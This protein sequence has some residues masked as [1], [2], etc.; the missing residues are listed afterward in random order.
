MKS[1]YAKM[2]KG[3]T[4]RPAKF[5][6]PGEL[7][8]EFGHGQKGSKTIRET[9]ENVGASKNI[10][11]TKRL[12]AEEHRPHYVSS[13]RIVGGVSSHTLTLHFGDDKCKEYDF[14]ED[15]SF[16][17]IMNMCRKFID[18]YTDRFIVTDGDGRRLKNDKDLLYMLEEHHGVENIDIYLELDENGQPLLFKMPQ[19][20]SSIA[21]I[22]N[23]PQCG[24]VLNGNSGE[25]RYHETNKSI[26]GELAPQKPRNTRG[27]N[28]NRKIVRLK[29]TEKLEI[30]F[31]NNR[32]VGEN[33]SN[34]SRHLGIIV[35][36]TNICP[37][38]VKTW[39]D[40]TES[41]RQHMWDCVKECFSNPNIELYRE[42]TLDHMGALWTTWRSSLN[43]MYVI[44]AKLKRRF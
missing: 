38:R 9:S 1:M 12:Q 28:K 3:G 33:H 26:E 24:D 16:L 20:I 5:I 43:A 22:P 41:S 23:V 31:Y 15:S 17:D 27:K 39:K 8:K 6:A 18:I 2:N 37:V 19:D 36:S 7:A 40:I 35:R 44:N 10:C 4:Q 25:T 29:N 42:H 13:Q 32:A 34:W 14:T 30:Q 21:H 11:G